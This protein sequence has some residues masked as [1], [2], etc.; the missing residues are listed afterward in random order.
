MATPGECELRIDHEVAHL[1]AHDRC[2]VAAG[3][4][5]VCITSDDSEVLIFGPLP[6][7]RAF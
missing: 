5:D 7:P 4:G 3:A 2:V 1:L 6:E